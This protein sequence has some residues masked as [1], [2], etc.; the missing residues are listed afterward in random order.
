MD[1]TDKTIRPV[2]MPRA[3]SRRSVVR[4]GAE[5][6]KTSILD[7]DRG[8]PLVVEPAVRGI[9]LSSWISLNRSFVND[10]LPKYGAVLF[11]G[12]PISD[13][14]AFHGVVESLGIQTMHYME[15]ATPRTQLSQGVYTS[16]EF[17]ADQSIALHNEL[18]Y[19][20]TWPMRICFCCLEPA[21]TQ[22]ATPIA[23]VRRV[24]ARIP[25]DVVEEFKQKHWMLLRNFGDGLSLPWQ[26]T[27]RTDEPAVVEEYCRQNLIDYEWRE[28]DRLR[29]RQVRPAVAIHPQ[30]GEQVWFNHAAFWHVSSLPAA[31]REV[32]NSDFGEQ[33]IP[34]NTYFGD[35]S[36]IADSTIQQL[37]NAYDAETVAFPWQQGDF[38]LLD[39]MLV[40]HGRQPFTGTRRVIV[41]MGDPY[42]RPF[43]LLS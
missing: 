4:T 9:D 17:P 7:L 40:A 33:G 19:V 23:D 41:S 24:L 27:F 25:S 11:R 43:P 32:F 38:L 22:G 42:S 31:A 30:T 21:T 8:L 16:T 37:R 20:T 3:G 18:S 29:T 5:M 36:R 35:G 1:T 6:V 10:A 15:G 26:K 2:V 14:R 12:F 13:T 39:N 34:Y 28:G